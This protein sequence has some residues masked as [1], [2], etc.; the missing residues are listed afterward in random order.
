MIAYMETHPEA[1]EEAVQLAIS[2]KQP[3]AWRAAWLLWS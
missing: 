3:Y 1:Y 2:D